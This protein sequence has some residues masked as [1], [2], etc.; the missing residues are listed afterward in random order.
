M[1]ELYS[2]MSATGSADADLLVVV[3]LPLNLFRISS[4]QPQSYTFSSYS[5]WKSLTWHS[6]APFCSY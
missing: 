6:P 5:C 3:M 1:V 4:Y 2:E